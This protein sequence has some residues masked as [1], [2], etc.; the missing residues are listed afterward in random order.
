MSTAIARIYTPEGFVIATDGR[1]TDPD[2]GTWFATQKTFSIEQPARRLA[3]SLAGTAVVTPKNSKEAV[4]TFASQVQTV[5]ATLAE[6]K[7][8]SLYE[9]ARLLAFG[10]DARLKEARKVAKIPPSQDGD[11]PSTTQIFLDGYYGK[12]PK[13]A[14]IDF[15]HDDQIEPEICG[16]TEDAFKYKWWGSALVSSVIF[17]E[18]DP[19]LGAY[20]LAEYKTPAVWPRTLAEAV[21]MAKRYVGA[22]C[23]PEALAIDEKVCSLCG[24]PIWVAT[25][26]FEEG[27]RWVEG[28]PLA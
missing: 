28:P 12:H 2:D 24:P 18:G 23:D 14:R 27:F 10:L 5:A 25:L 1:A 19:R 9:Y 8:S 21:S 7:I 16:N 20:K 17:D 6:Q 4:F 15:I 11:V 3:Y 26:T 22:H 13:R